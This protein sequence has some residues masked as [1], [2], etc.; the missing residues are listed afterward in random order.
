MGLILAGLAGGLGKGLER[1]TDIME[2][3]RTAEEAEDN[4]RGRMAYSQELADEAKEK[5]RA[6]VSERMKAFRAEADTWRSEHPKASVKD[7]ITAFSD[8]PYADL[9]GPSLSA[10]K[11]ISEDED[12]ALRRDLAM[13]ADK[14]ASQSNAASLMN[15][16]LAQKKWANAEAQERAKKEL[17]DQYLGAKDIDPLLAQQYADELRIRH[18]VTVDP[19]KPG[20][21][22][23]TT[24]T[25]EFDEEGGEIEKTQKGKERAVSAQEKV[26]SM[27]KRS[28]ETAEIE[29]KKYPVYVGPDGN[30]YVTGN[31]G[32][33][34]KKVQ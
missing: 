7:F 5:E 16:S 11:L 9:L 27:M 34:W 33:S 25:K 32:K 19:E 13:R 22:E 8:S 10:A 2:K 29:G 20:Q 24:K 4:V 14:R 15:A 18:G 3:R 12:R 31:R 1:Y 30:K 28:D 21:I 26:L 6:R 23:T 17:I